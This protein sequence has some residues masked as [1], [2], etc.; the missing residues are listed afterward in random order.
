MSGTRRIRRDGAM[1]STRADTPPILTR[2]LLMLA[3]IAAPAWAGI[4]NSVHDFSSE[5]WSGGEVCNVCHPPHAASSG[6]DGP[7]WNHAVSTATYTVYS[8]PTM[9]VTAEQ[10]APGGVSRLC[11]SC[12]DGTIAID[13]FGGATGSTTITGK[14]NLG[15][16]LS[17]DHPIGIQWIHQTQT[18]GSSNCINCHVSTWNPVTSSFDLGSA[19]G[20]LKFFNRKVECPS[21]HDV[22]NSRV[23]DVKLL[24]KPLAGSQI[25][26]H[27]HPK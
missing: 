26:L 1:I 10:P 21:C 19:G 9:D 11:L 17:N 15:T 3:I 12:H 14:A 6:T 5:G 13:S 16:D 8:S 27:C 22:H 25:C 7:L 2:L 23:K 18:T 4:E 24:R 20:E